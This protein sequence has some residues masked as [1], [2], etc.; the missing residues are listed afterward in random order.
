M[1]L[2][3]LR[4]GPRPPLAKPYVEEFEEYFGIAPSFQIEKVR[5]LNKVL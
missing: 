5:F 2:N 1:N 3:S 4:L